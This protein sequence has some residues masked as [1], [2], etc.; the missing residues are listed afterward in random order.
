[1]GD[2]IFPALDVAEKARI[3]AHDLAVIRDPYVAI[4]LVVVVMFV[5]IA[6]VKMPR[7]DHS[8]TRI[9]SRETLGRLWHNR[10]YRWG[11]VAQVFYV[12]AQ[13]MVWTFI[14]QYADNLGINKAVAQ[15]F[16]IVA[17][18]L[19]LGGRFVGTYMMKFVRPSSML[20]IF[21]IGA[22]ACTFGSIF[23][24]GKAGLYS[25]VGISLFMSIMFPSIYGVA[26]EKVN[27]RDTS[28][29]AAFLVMAIVGGALMPPLQASIIDC[30]E[31]AGC[32]L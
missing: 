19:F 12:A 14:I 31:I 9:K 15:T 17:M 2:I 7:T 10:E 29:G 4:G 11:V 5:V 22:A 16:N 24:V 30:G 8:G 6:L 1:M 25:L 27:E 3:R 18:C 20:V 32:R 21:G 26:L 28:L 23:I 13:I